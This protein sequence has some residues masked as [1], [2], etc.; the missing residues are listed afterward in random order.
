MLKGF[1]DFLLRGN[2][3]DLAV[4][5]VVGAAFTA[6]V[7]AFTENIVN[8]LVAALGGSEEMGFG[9][10]II[11]GNAETFVDI[12]AVITAA[13]NFVIIAAV[14]YFILIVP[15]THAKKRFTVEEQAALTD[16]ELLTE[17]RD[18]LSESARRDPA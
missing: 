9:F 7:T 3:L 13:I 6:I 2:V 10:E 8:P 1:K 17:I 5:V 14:V 15:Y 16:V 4:A 12:G 11:A 18:L